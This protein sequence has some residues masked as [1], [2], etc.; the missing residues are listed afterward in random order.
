MMLLDYVIDDKSCS[1]NVF[2]NHSER[3]LC[4]PRM[5]G[6]RVLINKKYSNYKYEG[7]LY[8]DL[9]GK[10][11]LSFYPNFS[12]KRIHLIFDE[13]PDSFVKRTG[14]ISVV[15]INFEIV[16]NALNHHVLA[17]PS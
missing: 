1:L 12:N 4:S 14:R 5:F 7:S 2:A 13:L 3:F 10:F 11:V 16:T 6:T 8:R 9:G 15:H 17:T